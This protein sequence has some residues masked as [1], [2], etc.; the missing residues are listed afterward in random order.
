MNPHELAKSVLDSNL[1]W[2]NN[3]IKTLSESL[4]YWKKEKAKILLELDKLEQSDDYD[5]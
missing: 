4:E 5:H 1:I 2:C 3:N